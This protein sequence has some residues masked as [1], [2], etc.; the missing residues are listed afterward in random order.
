MKP[1][2]VFVM[3]W[4]LIHRFNVGANHHSPANKTI[5]INMINSIIRAD[6]KYLGMNEKCIGAGKK[7]IGTGEKCFAPTPHNPHLVN[8]RGETF[9]ARNQSSFTR[10][11]SSFTRNQTEMQFTDATI[12]NF[13]NQLIIKKN[14][15]VWR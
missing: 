2:K 7:C 5:K 8:R 14:L 11:E 1:S 10:K 6:E 3:N 15:L 4:A 12:G 9:F 13:C